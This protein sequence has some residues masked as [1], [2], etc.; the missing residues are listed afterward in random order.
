[1]NINTNIYQAHA[2]MN[3]Q[4]KARADSLLLSMGEFGQVAS[5]QA[6]HDAPYHYANN[7]CMYCVADVIEMVEAEQAGSIQ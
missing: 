4:A 5:S 3:S 6:E 7:R 1:M 2:R